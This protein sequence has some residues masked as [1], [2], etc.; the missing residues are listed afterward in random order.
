MRVTDSTPVEDAEPTSFA[1]KTKNWYERHKP[2]IGVALGVGVA[3]AAGLVMVAHLA[4]KEDAEG[5]DA[6]DIED[7]EPVSDREA[8]DEPR[9]SAPDPYRAPFLRRLPAGQQVSEE[10][11]ARYREQMG[12][13]VPSGYT[14]V[15]RWKF[16]SDSPEDEATGEAAA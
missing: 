12:D 16:L 10:A 3:L 9:R 1:E 7:S 14:P 5:Y 4:E 13:E 8:T 2:K 15:R 6:E 11:K